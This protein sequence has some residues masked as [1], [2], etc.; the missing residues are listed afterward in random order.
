MSHETSLIAQ[1]VKNPLAMQETW[2]R[3]LGQ[4]DPLEKVMATQL[5]YSCHGQRSLTGYS[6][7]G[8]KELDTTERL[9]LTE[10][11]GFSREA[12]P[13]EW[14]ISTGTKVEK[15]VMRVLQCLSYRTDVEIVL[16]CFRYQF[17]EFGKIY[18]CQVHNGNGL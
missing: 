7:W 18:P 2:I 12:E 14:D 6:P 5:Q 3:S 11:S 1:M 9:T 4:K 13:I 17:K 8:H 10:E 15:R 16:Y